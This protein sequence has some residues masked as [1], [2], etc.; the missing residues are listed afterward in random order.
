MHVV[1]VV[2]T[3]APPYRYA[4]ERGACRC[5]DPVRA[6]RCAD[7]CE[8]IAMPTWLTLKNGQK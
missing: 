4:D 3:E 2:A 1:V 8:R 6:Y 7:A 5:A